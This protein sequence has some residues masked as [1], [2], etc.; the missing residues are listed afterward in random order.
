MFKKLIHTK[1]KAT[2]INKEHISGN[3]IKI[4]FRTD[5]IDYIPGQYI[6]L[7]IGNL[8]PRNYSIYRVSEDGKVFSIIVNINGNG[9]GRRTIK[10]FIVYEQ[11]Y[12]IG[13]I[14]DFRFNRNDNTHNKWFIA[15]GSG[16]SPLIPMILENRYKYK[17]KFFFSARYKEDIF[18][19]KI[20]GIDTIISL[21]QENSN[22]NGKFGRVT[23]TLLDELKKIDNRDDIS[24][25]ICGN[26]K[27]VTD[28]KNFLINQNIDLS[29]IY[30]EKF[31]F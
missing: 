25:Y 10:E 1:R 8:I 18:N 4:D 26:P 28:T 12:F 23:D 11:V 30:F 16:I 6:T 21:T 3:L 22:W 5:H 29:K 9:V 15:T 31:G 7:Y 2:I 13:P 24:F 14:G 19:M 17:I 20:N 27:M